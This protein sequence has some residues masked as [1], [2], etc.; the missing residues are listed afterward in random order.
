MSDKRKIVI[1]SKAEEDHAIVVPDEQGEKNKPVGGTRK[2]WIG[3]VV[4]GIIL[5][6]FIAAG[7]WWFCTRTDGEA[8]A[9][10]GGGDDAVIQISNQS[11]MQRL[12][13]KYDLDLE[14]SDY[15]V[16]RTTSDANVELGDFLATLDL[17]T[18]DII[19]IVRE[20]GRLGLDS[21]F[22]GDRITYFFKDGYVKQ[23]E[24]LCIEPYADKRHWFRLR[25]DQDLLT[26]K[27]LKTVELRRKESSCVITG[28]QLYSAIFDCDMH[29]QLI[30]KMEEILKWSVDFYHIEPGDKFRIIYDEKYI[31]NQLVGVE[32]IHAIEFYHRGDKITVFGVNDRGA[33]S[34]YSDQGKSLEQKFL[35]APLKFGRISSRFSLARIHP[36]T[37]KKKFHGGTDYAAPEGTPI[38]SVADGVVMGTRYTEYSGN[39]IEVKHNNTYTTKYLHISEYAPGMKRGR[40]VKQG[41]VIAY[42]GQTGKNITGPH[43]C[44]RFVKNG[45]EVDFLNEKLPSG[46]KKI[47]DHLSADFEAARD[48]L[49]LVLDDI[50]W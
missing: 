27:F 18:P 20:Y 3:Y 36:V 19:R 37:G 29:Y 12:L 22:V 2:A 25:L 15:D 46:G 21:I 26:E 6:V 41:E 16:E 1:K 33:R 13:D 39:L 47:A 31:D 14:E 23:T 43:V 40:K 24:V 17:K 4:I 11:K 49:S 44:F 8:S 34:F 32:S 48:T 9:K 35:K 30:Q 50:D 10:K 42:V 45:Q 38:L 5:S 28:F 7:V